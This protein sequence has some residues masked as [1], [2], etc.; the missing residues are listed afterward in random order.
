M[1]DDERLEMLDG[2][3]ERLND[4]RGTHVLLVEGLKDVAALRSIGVEG[5]FRCVQ[6]T[7]GPIRAAEYVWGIGKGAV[8]LTDWDRRGGSL[9]RMLRDNLSS[10][11]VEYDDRIRGD[12]AFACRP[13]AKDVESVDSVYRSLSQKN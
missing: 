3:V 10:L 5:E 12:L 2:I 13:Y 8:I 6:S 11:G 7:G 1:N 4:L 9:A